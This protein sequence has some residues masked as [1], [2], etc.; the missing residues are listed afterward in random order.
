MGR[1][2]AQ[3]LGRHHLVRHG[4]DHIRPGHEHVGA[5]LHHEDEIRHGRGVNRTTGAGPHD[6]ADLRHHARGQDVALE[7]LAIGGQRGHTFLDARAARIVDPDDRCAVLH[8]HIHDLADLGGMGFRHRPTKHGEILTEHID[9][10]PVDRAPAGHDT[11][12]ARLALLHAEIGAAMSHEHVVFFETA[13]IQQQFD[14]LARRQF[15]LGML[16][17]DPRLSATQSGPGAP[18][19]QFLK[20]VFHRMFPAC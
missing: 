2:S 10:A 17:V 6:Q 9:H 19:F 11:I 18:L 5:V 1:G 8:R 13:F 15:A 7:H 14:P 16:R 4:L 20:N 3:F 12:A